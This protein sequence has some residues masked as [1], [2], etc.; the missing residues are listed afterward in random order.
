MLIQSLP[1]IR[2]LAILT[3]SPALSSASGRIH[4]VTIEVK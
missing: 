2:S 3:I 4:K 1:Q